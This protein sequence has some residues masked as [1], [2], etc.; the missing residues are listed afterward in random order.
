MKKSLFTLIAAIFAALATA[1][2]NPSAPLQYDMTFKG[3]G[4][5]AAVQT[6][7]VEN[8]TRGTLLKL[9]G[10][11]VLRLTNTLST[12]IY[13]LTEAPKVHSVIYPNP[14]FGAANLIFANRTAGNV[15][16]TVTDLSGRTLASNT[17]NLKTGKQTAVLPAMPSG[18]YIVAL[19]GNGINESVKWLSRGGGNGGAIHLEGATDNL[20]ANI[21]ASNVVEPNTVVPN[22]VASNIVETGRAP[23]LLRTSNADVVEM[24]YADGELLRFTGVSGNM[25]TIVMNTPTLSHDITFDFYD[26]T[27]AN[28]YHYPIVNAG[29]MLWM[30]EDLRNIPTTV[31]PVRA[32]QSQWSGYP[33]DQPKQA[34]YD[35][36]TGN[37]SLGGYYNYAG[38]KAA[39][40]QGWNLPTAGEVDYMFGKLGGYDRAANLLK[41]RGNAWAQQQ[42]VP[43]TVSFGAVAMGELNPDGTFSGEDF[44]VKYWT[45]STK[46]GIPIFWGIENAQVL[47]NKDITA[48]TGYGLR[49]RGCRPAPSA[50]ADVA[51]RFT[52]SSGAPQHAPSA[53][54]LF[55]DGPLGE[56]YTLSLEKQNLWQSF[57]A[58]TA[59]NPVMQ[60]RDYHTGAMVPLAANTGYTNRLQK[61]AAV[62]NSNGRQNLAV[63]LWS[64]GSGLTGNTIDGDG[65][66]SIVLFGDSTQGYAKVDSI[67]LPTQYNLPPYAGFQRL[68]SKVSSDYGAAGSLI[69]AASNNDDVLRFVAQYLFRG[70]EIETKAESATSGNRLSIPELLNA[71][72]WYAKRMQL[73][74]ADFNADG[75]GDFVVMV[76]NRID[77]YSGVSPYPVLY[78][79]TFGSN[80]LRMAVGDV[81]GD[82]NPDIAVIYPLNTD[83]AQVEVFSGGN[84]NTTGTAFITVPAGVHNDIKIGNIKP[85][86]KN[87]IITITRKDN[88]AIGKLR[89]IDYDTNV[90]GK[91]AM[92]SSANTDAIAS[93]ALGSDND[94]IT[95][96]RF[97]GSTSPA[98][99]VTQNSV[100]R[101][102]DNGSNNFTRYATEAGGNPDTSITFDSYPSYPSHIIYYTVLADNIV[103][104]NFNND[105]D[106]KETIEYYRS[107]VLYNGNYGGSVNSTFAG[108][109]FTLNNGWIE[110]TETQ[111]PAGLRAITAAATSFVN[112]SKTAQ[113][114]STFR[115]NYTATAH[116][117]S[118]LYQLY[119]RSFTV[120]DISASA[121]NYG[122]LASARSAEPGKGL[123][124]TGHNTSMSEPRIYALLAAPPFYAFKPDGTP[125]EYNNFSNMGTSW[126]KSQ[127][128]GTGTSNESSNK[129]TAIFGFEQEFNAPIVGTKL[130]G[131]DFTAKLS[132]EWTSGTE[133][134]TVTTQSIEFTAPQNDAVILTA[135]FFDTY[136][137]E[138]VS[139]GNPDEIGSMLNISLPSQNRTLGLNLDDYNRLAADN[140]ECPNLKQIF[141]HKAGF[142]LT[143]PNDKTQIQSNIAGSSILWAMPF[144]GNDFVT[145]GSGVDVN[146][147]ITLDTETTT[148]AGFTFGVEM[149]LVA[150]VLGVKAGAGYGY[151][152]TNS[153]SHTEG[154]GHSIA[155]N[156]SGLNS[157]GEA[158]LSHFRW[159]IGWY[160]YR[161]GGQE[162][163]VVQ[164]VVKE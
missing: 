91:L 41:E 145:L 127:V 100:Y 47:L 151:N 12:G 95:L 63:A 23:S 164:Y 74:S 155:G 85:G 28:G 82:L 94:N 6:V 126:G 99:V 3:R 133:T 117:T 86:G 162:F 158:G 120:T 55:A 122:L 11:E 115:I 153:S 80:N 157:L 24:L 73:L 103:A 140:P 65:Y 92:L 159:T 15:L 108:N 33:S 134:N 160:K 130:G 20:P 121:Y 46:G 118:P 40:P 79:K 98:D 31:V 77:V 19:H 17:F 93:N 102:N 107:S 26:C 152:N 104:G 22:V 150:N 161:L 83:N 147:S 36:S 81:D 76:G 125:Y 88:D 163:P 44:R 105:A 75:V 13:D 141:K 60:Y 132:S 113:T 35:F 14:S 64:R 10:T 38:A 124:Y 61:A 7:T 34:Y 32:S 52:F 43:D 154:E 39:L 62:D 8:L 143:Y 128:T 18:N 87:S 56:M 9:D 116:I 16:I 49:V 48:D 136:T 59:T 1:Q 25:T 57:N 97:R 68:I 42:N 101:F 58:P 51:E 71:H 109:P 89:V 96:C 135:T 50:Y 148:T 146:R 138:V 123:K 139:S 72:K 106:G 111:M 149:E 70:L 37:A 114:N 54:A 84:L 2:E 112:E 90:P 29:G 131:I 110:Y 27:D 66:V 129:A 4:E 30:A 156:V 119:L 78:S 144:G 53:T 5:S 69:G 45:R 21:A 137:Y 142:P 67:R